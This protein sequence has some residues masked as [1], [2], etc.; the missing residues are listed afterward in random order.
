M[1][2]SIDLVSTIGLQGPAAIV[3]CVQLAVPEQ[4]PVPSVLELTENEFGHVMAGEGDTVTV[5]SVVGPT[6]LV[7]PGPVG[8]I[9]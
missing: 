5:T 2:P 7:G 9:R 3:G 6:Q 4:L 1:L 8:V